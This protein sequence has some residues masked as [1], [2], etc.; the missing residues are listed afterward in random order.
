M[1]AETADG[2]ARVTGTDNGSLAFIGL[3]A[4][5]AGMA[6][7]LL[8]G[9]ATVT[10]HNRSPQKAR[11]LVEAGATA[12]SSPAG[13]VAEA[14]LVLLSLADE[15]AVDAVLFGEG[16]LQG[17]I[18]PGTLIVNTSTTSPEYARTVPQ[19]VAAFG[20]RY[21]EACVVGNPQH[22]HAGE[23]RIFA[24]GLPADFAAAKALLERLGRQVVYVGAPGRASVMKLVFNVL[25]GAQL[26]AVAE[27]VS[28]GERA[29]LDRNA[30][31]GAIG[32]SGFS[33]PVM[34]FRTPL[35]QQRRYEPASFRLRL[36]SKDLHLVLAEAALTGTSL[37]VV[38]TAARRYDDAIAAGFGDVDAAA[39]L[40]GQEHDLGDPGRAPAADGEEL[41]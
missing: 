35:M 40:A 27:A 3:G 24:A 8:A 4:M 30:L 7:R 28:F 36:M 39:I 2:R 5:G 13:A 10:V 21:L 34:A 20:G 38:A 17:A 37:P 41:G 32:N 19:R 18:R 16:G 14:D 11:E 29:G 12:A 23:L 22:A 33:S 26:A 9:G 15:H 6:A 1:T 31:L 25:L